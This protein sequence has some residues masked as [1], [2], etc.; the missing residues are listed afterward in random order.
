MLRALLRRLTKLLL[1]LTALSVLL[2]L[3]LRWVPP[4]F[5]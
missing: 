1:W 4:P 3:V 5:T 2:V